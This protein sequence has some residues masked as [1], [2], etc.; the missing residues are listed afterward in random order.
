MVE[1]NSVGELLDPGSGVLAEYG[2]TLKILDYYYCFTFLLYL[3][4]K[5][6]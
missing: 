2:D 4:V 6:N 3:I 5:R 1:K